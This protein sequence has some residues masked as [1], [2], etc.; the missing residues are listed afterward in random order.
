MSQEQ[1]VRTQ[2]NMRA[3]APSVPMKRCPSRPYWVLNGQVFFT[4]AAYKEARDGTKSR[5]A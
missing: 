3:T 4:L 1:M 2:P 5:G